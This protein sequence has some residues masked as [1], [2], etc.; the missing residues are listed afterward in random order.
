[1]RR[2]VPAAL[3]VV[4]CVA[5]RVP[6]AAAHNGPPFPLL[7]D[8]PVGPYTVSVWTDPDIGTGTFLVVLERADGG[9]SPPPPAAVRVA[10]RPQSGRLPEAV[11][12]A[13]PKR[14]RHGLHYAAKVAF[15]ERELWDV[16]ILIEGP[17]GGGELRA[18]VEATPAGLP[19]PYALALYALPF[20]AVGFL[21][22]RAARVRR[23]RA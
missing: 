5:L 3:V 1:M 10:V 21:W 4:V 18:A 22:F 2:A 13:E 15:D 19:G 12:E 20:L 14:A 7:V 16:R 8:R 9:K 17:E 23:R 6:L 11:S